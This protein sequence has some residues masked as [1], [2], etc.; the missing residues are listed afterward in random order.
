[1][2]QCLFLQDILYRIDRGIIGKLTFGD[3]THATDTLLD[4]QLAGT[5]VDVEF[6]TDVTGDFIYTGKA[7]ISNFDLGAETGTSVKVSISFT[8]NGNITNKHSCLIMTDVSIEIK[9]KTQ[10]G[11]R[12]ESFRILGRKW[13]LP[14]VNEVI[15]KWQSL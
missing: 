12:L 8:G 1:M 10:A 5:E 3:T 2:V 11:I 6:T 7:F 4:A 15:Q 9:E 14:G 13:Q